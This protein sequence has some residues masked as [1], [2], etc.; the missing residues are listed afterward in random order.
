[1]KCG[2]SFGATLAHFANSSLPRLAHMPSCTGNVA[3]ADEDRCEGNLTQGPRDFF[4]YK[5]PI[6][7]WFP[8][9]F[10][11][12]NSSTEPGG[13]RI[14]GDEDF[15]EW[16]GRF[17]GLFRSPK[18]RVASAYNHFVLGTNETLPPVL[19]HSNHSVRMQYLKKYAAVARGTMTK[20]LS[21]IYDMNP[22]QC[23]F[24]FDESIARDPYCSGLCKKC[25]NQDPSAK[26]LKVALAR[27]QKFAFVGLTEYFDLSVCLFHAM[28]GGECRP[29]EFANMRPSHYLDDFPDFLKA[30][31]IDDPYDGELFKAASKIFWSNVA[32]Y[33]VTTESCSRMC[34]NRYANFTI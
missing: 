5:Y 31:D 26:S 25:L 10:W 23:E 12:T 28:F 9:V 32:H 21:G 7:E 4:I 8:D 22:I 33:N 24:H 20:M 34:P 2:S 17:V 6:H 15:K 27:L 16:Q 14:I 3:D 11:T 1:M 18:A 19:R 13:H 29:V 30:H